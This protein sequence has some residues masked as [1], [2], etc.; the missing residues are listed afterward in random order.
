[1][2]AVAVALHLLHSAT[3]AFEYR[4]SPPAALF[5]FNRAAACSPVPDAV[6]NPAYLPLF[7]YPYLHASGAIPYSMKGLYASI[8]RAGYGTRGFGLQA[9]WSR[10]GFDAYLEHVAGADIGFMPVRYVSRG[11]GG[12]YYR[13]AIDTP[14]TGARAG[15]ADGR[16]SL[17]VS[18]FEWI[19]IA[20][21]QENIASIFI[22]K[23]RDLLFPGWSAGAALRPMRGL[24]VAYN[25]NLTTHGYVHSVSA[26]AAVLRHFIIPAGYARETMTSSMSI[27]V[28]YRNVAASYGLRYHPH[29]GLTH[30]AGVTLSTGEIP[31]DPISYGRV[32]ARFRGRAAPIDLRTCTHEELEAIPWLSRDHAARI[33]RYRET[34]GPL[35]RAALVQIGMTEKDVDR[36][37]ARATGLAPVPRSERE[38]YLA[39]AKTEAA[40]K[41]AFASLVGAGVP[42]A[43]ALDLAEMAAGGERRRLA[44]K[45]KNLGGLSAETKKAAARICG[46][47][48]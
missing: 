47:S 10:F 46:V 36:L 34:E 13:L 5:P 38:A 28:A 35:T 24:T 20:F 31:V 48:Y 40:R 32:R 15:L 14:E 3:L 27:T 11:A 4:E 8:I 2:I 37:M 26:A 42:P 23:R 12:R 19:D 9:S 18:P 45:I 41:R 25:L 7:G 43:T 30:S 17:L 22:K 6:S 33:I 16:A 29:L 1:M 39:R 21:Q 44:E